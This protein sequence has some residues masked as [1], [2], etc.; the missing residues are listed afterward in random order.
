MELLQ[1]GCIDREAAIKLAS[2]I[3]HIHNA[4]A[5]EATS[6]DQWEELSHKFL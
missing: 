3:G 2:F 4:T 5:R 6:D 1:E